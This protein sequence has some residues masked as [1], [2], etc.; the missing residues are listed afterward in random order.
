[1]VLKTKK[2][3]DIPKAKP[4]SPNRLT[5]I[6]FIAALLAWKRV[7]Q[8]LINKNEANPIPS[9]P[10]NI[11]TKLSALTSINIKA[12]NNDKYDINRAK[13][14]SPFKYSVEYK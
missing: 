9:H 1:V 12:V 11:T 7:F 14:G 13:C 8:K 10:K 4:I 5:N 6:A 3:A 2:Q